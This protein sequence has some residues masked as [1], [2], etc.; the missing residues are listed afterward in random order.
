[1]A[2]APWFVNLHSDKKKKKKKKTWQQGGKVSIVMG[3]LGI[4][5]AASDSFCD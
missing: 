5:D 1:M 3:T 4:S 2:R